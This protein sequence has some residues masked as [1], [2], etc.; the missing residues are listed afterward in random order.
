LDNDLILRQF[1]KIEE[2]VEG[3]IVDRNALEAQ[4]AELKQTI[5][6]LEQELQR[7]VEVENRF[8]E[9]RSQIRSKIDGLLAKFD[10]VTGSQQ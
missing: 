1:E 9:E 3:L 8:A 7:K 4:N 6:R 10:A 2:K 5:A